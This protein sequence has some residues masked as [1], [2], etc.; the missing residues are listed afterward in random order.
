MRARLTTDAFIIKAKERH[1]DRYDYSLANYI[2]TRTKVAIKCKEHGVFWQ[3]PE[4]HLRGQGCPGCAY[5]SMR[6]STDVFITKAN[7]RHLGRYDYSSTDYINCRTKVAIGCKEHGTFWQRPDEHLRGYG[8]P[9]CALIYCTSECETAWLDS[10]GIAK[11]NRNK[12][13]MIDGRIY[14]VDAYVPRSKTVYE[15]YGD[16]WHGNPKVF[17]KND[18]NPMTGE[19][20]GQLLKGT[21]EREQRLI[22]AGYK[23]VNIWESDWKESKNE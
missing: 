9:T 12:R 14:T 20:F 15:F 21:V 18:I 22:E 13:L 6:S 19:S 11:H 3:T 4:N 2:T 1:Q 17:S 10:K 5:A 8:C 16:F 7:L 23:V